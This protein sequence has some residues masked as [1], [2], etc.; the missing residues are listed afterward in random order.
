MHNGT[1]L[2]YNT[3]FPVQLFACG[4]G[5]FPVFSIVCSQGSVDYCRCRVMNVLIEVFLL[6]AA[7]QLFAYG[8]GEFQSL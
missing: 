6:P 5:E 4:L 3:F 8:F 7:L 1:L 2:L